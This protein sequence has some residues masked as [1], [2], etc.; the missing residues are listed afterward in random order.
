MCCQEKKKPNLLIAF[1]ATLLII[2]L[3]F[4]SLL[5]VKGHNYTEFH[6]KTVQI[7][8]EC[9]E[10]WQKHGVRLKTRIL[11]KTHEIYKLKREIRIL[12][13]PNPTDVEISVI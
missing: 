8:D 4:N 10:K 1:L 3:L 12:R 11:D 13:D 2:S 6:D 9:I 7:Y 5:I